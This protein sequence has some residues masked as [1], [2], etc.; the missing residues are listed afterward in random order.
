MT[1]SIN[2]NEHTGPAPG[3]QLLTQLRRT[4]PIRP[5]AYYEH[6]IIAER[7]ATQLLGLLNQHEP[8][9]SLDWLT[10]GQLGNIEVV[11]VPRWKMESASGITTWRDGR[12]VIGVNKSQPQARRR[13]TLAHEFKHALDAHRDKITYGSL[14]ADQRERIADYFAATYLMPKLLL[15]RVW[16]RG[17]QDPEALAGL[18][19]VSLPA[20][21]KRLKYL[22]F[23]DDQPDRAARTYFRRS[24]SSVDIQ[25]SQPQRD[26]A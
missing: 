22:Q 1:D 13:F 4:M 21:H 12:W 2:T 19:K 18:F 11:L 23:I 24:H 8:G 15:R 17:I 25:L 7:Q 5:L 26:V 3:V 6:L 9:V 20:M 14:S 10:D 16:T